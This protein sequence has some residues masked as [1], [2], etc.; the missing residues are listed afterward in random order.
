MKNSRCKFRY[1]LLHAVLYAVLITGGGTQAAAQSFLP[2]DYSAENE[3]T[4]S[5]NI[6]DIE[7]G[8]F[9]RGLAKR[10]NINIIVG[11][12]VS[13]TISVSLHNIPLTKA[14]Y[15]VS[16]AN[17][18]QCV[19]KNGI[20]FILKEEENSNN[21]KKSGMGN[22][23]KSF[24]I[25]YAE[26]GEVRKL[27]EDIVGD[28]SVAVHEEAKTLIVHDTPENIAKVGKVLKQV[29][30]A[31]HQ[32]LIEAKILEIQLGENLSFGVDWEKTFTA[33]NYAG[34]LTGKNFA[35]PPD[36]EG[37]SGFFMEVF[38]NNQKLKANLDALESQSDLNVLATPKLWAVDGKSAEILIGGR[39]GY[40]EVTTTETSTLQSVQFL[41]TG[42][43]LNLTPNISKDGKILMEIHPSIS[44]GTIDDLG[45]PSQRTTEVTTAV[46][47]EHGDTIFIGG[48]I[49]QVKQKN[50]RKIPFIGSIPLVGTFFGRTEDKVAK[51]EIIVIITPYIV[52]PEERM[53]K[54]EKVEIVERAEE[55]HDKDESTFRKLFSQERMY[56]TIQGT[57]DRKEFE[58]K[59]RDDL[60]LLDQKDVPSGKGDNPSGYS[61]LVSSFYEEKNA[62]T[63]T[64][65]LKN[66]GYPA[67]L[68]ATSDKAGTPVSAVKIGPFSSHKVAEEFNRRLKEE[69]GI[70]A[71]TIEE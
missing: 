3:E 21:D 27:V 46:L 24:R 42:T 66:K 2:A 70:T 39:L 16:R 40:Y 41:D 20:Y 57:G 19:K 60:S 49:R 64:E 58:I 38:K 65:N 45:L 68:L 47:A 7:I 31:P 48:L 4:I 56:E 62:E 12:D 29:D 22:T 26:I 59:D 53:T 9:F 67:Y 51:N 44:E 71:L 28:D 34:T 25:N 50:R 33:G 37:A 13:G 55:V 15:A 18:Y 11:K 23:V 14:L 52:S 36:T 61:L 63:M 69:V 1:F 35:L 54:Q 32:V 8:D 6:K 43:Q 10:R 5:I 17:G 30:Y